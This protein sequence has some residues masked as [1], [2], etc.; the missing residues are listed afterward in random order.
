[1]LQLCIAIPIGKIDNGIPQYNLGTSRYM[2]IAIANL[3]SWMSQRAIC[4]QHTNSWHSC[5]HAHSAGPLSI[6]SV[7]DLI[8]CNL[9]ACCC[10]FSQLFVDS[11]VATANSSVLPFFSFSHCWTRVGFHLRAQVGHS[12]HPP[13]MAQTPNPAQRMQ[14][15]CPQSCCCWS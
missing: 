9:P 4:W 1:M 11:K 3:K 5:S 6:V 7:T 14:L 13:H 15:G 8:Q 12:K 2:H 10:N